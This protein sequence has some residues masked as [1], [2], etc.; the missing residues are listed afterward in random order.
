MHDH[1]EPRRGAVG[2]F[3]V[4]GVGRDDFV[5]F[6]RRIAH[7]DAD[8]GGDRG[9]QERGEAG[10]DARDDRRDTAERAAD[11][12]GGPAQER[13]TEH[14]AQA[15]R[16]RPRADERKRRCERGPQQRRQH[17]HQAAPFVAELA[18]REESPTEQRF[19]R[20]QRHG[21]KPEQLHRQI[22]EDRARI[23][24]QVNGRLVGCVAERGVLHRPGGQR[25]GA[26]QRQ[27]DQRQPRELAHAAPHDVAQ[28]LREESDNV[29]AA[30]RCRHELVFSFAHDLVRKPVST[31]RDHA[32]HPNN[33]TRRC[34]AS[35]VASLS[36]T[37]ATRT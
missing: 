18:M 8:V 23:A 30:V 16:Q 14:A 7:R 4:V 29:D 24:E 28:M 33:S 13:V 10:D 31:F 25:D 20:E 32:R 22:G 35:A 34:S 5:L 17:P 9:G 1:A 12:R 21:G 15:C 37:I 36:C 3:L 27:R 19:R 26:E 11:Q 2:L 6:V